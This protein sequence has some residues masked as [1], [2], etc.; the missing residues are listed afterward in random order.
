MGQAK[1]EGLSMRAGQL[2]GIDLGGLSS[3]KLGFIWRLLILSSDDACLK[4]FADIMLGL[5]TCKQFKMGKKRDLLPI[6]YCLPSALVQVLNDYRLDD[7]RCHQKKTEI[8]A[9]LD[10]LDNGSLSCFWLFSICLCLNYL[11][12]G[13]SVDN[14]RALWLTTPTVHQNR[15]LE[16]LLDDVNSFCSLNITIPCNDWNHL[17]SQR[18][19]SYSG[20][21]I[22][23]ART[24][25]WQAVKATLPEPH[26][27]GSVS[28]VSL[29]TGGVKAYLS[30]ESRM[31]VPLEEIADPPSPA[32]VRVLDRDWPELAAGL[33]E[34]RLCTAIPLTKVKHWG[35]RNSCLDYLV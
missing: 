3:W 31:F 10:A 12:C 2:H 29:S 28:A 15:C 6:R 27:V 16:M 23:T 32:S 13:H 30:C 11:Y 8:F 18:T 25:T 34:Y 5:T 26:L 14:S 33:L 17:L 7:L 20:E 22:C 4:K 19:I 21:T 9:V 24:L 35:V 1:V